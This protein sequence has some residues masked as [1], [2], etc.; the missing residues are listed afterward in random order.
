MSQYEQIK[1]DKIRRLEKLKSV[2]VTTSQAKLE[3]PKT[4]LGLKEGRNGQEKIIDLVDSLRSMEILSSAITDLSNVR[5]EFMT[6]K[7]VNYDYNR[8]IQKH[9]LRLHQQ[10]SWATICVI[11]LLIGAPLGSIIRKGGYG[12]PLLVAILFYMIF[13][14]TTIFGEKLVKNGTME[15][16]QAAWLPC[17]ILSPFAF[18]L[19]IMALRDIKFN[20][21]WLSGFFAK[22]IQKSK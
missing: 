10:Y 8:M 13:I 2:E 5:D 3:T 19:T 22:F 12:Y 15:G 11:F 20:L 6:M 21:N 18:A 4:I 9:R 1:L 17:L 7:N 14:I 16:I